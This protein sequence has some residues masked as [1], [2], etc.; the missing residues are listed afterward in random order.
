MAYLTRT[1]FDSIDLSSSMG[2]LIAKRWQ[3]DL[4]HYRVS[5]YR[6]FEVL[7][8]IRDGAIIIAA[9]LVLFWI[10]FIS[11]N[12]LPRALDLKVFHISK[13]VTN[14]CSRV[15]SIVTENDCSLILDAGLQPRS[16]EPSH[17]TIRSL[18]S[19]LSA[20][21]RPRKVLSEDRTESSFIM[22]K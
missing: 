21:N 16:K 6:V 18:E 12:V 8:Y 4:C 2:H 11:L 22:G 19:T 5:F 7:H 17:Y 10:C 3:S 20:W 15:Y 1:N 13:E 14:L 9:V